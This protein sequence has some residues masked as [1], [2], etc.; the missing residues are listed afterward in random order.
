MERAADGDDRATFV[1]EDG[2]TLAGLVTV[3]LDGPN[4]T[5][6]QMWVDP[7]SR[8][9]GLGRRLVDAAIRWAYMRGAR[10]SELWVTEDNSA[11]IAL[12][13]RCGFE[14]TGATQPHPSQPGLVERE[15]RRGGGTP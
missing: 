13:L 8:R 7:A 14:F 12:Y 5:L 6:N 11:A 15:M 4:A 9:D 3:F 1:A 2:D 10:S